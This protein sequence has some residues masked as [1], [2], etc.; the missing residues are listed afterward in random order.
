MSV[1]LVAKRCSPFTPNIVL[2]LFSL[3]CLFVKIS[4]Q[5]NCWVGPDLCCSYHGL[6][7]YKNLCC[8]FSRFV[9]LVR[10]TW[11]KCWGEGG[12]GG[13]CTHAELSLSAIEL[14]GV[15]FPYRYLVQ[16]KGGLICLDL[17]LLSPCFRSWPFH[18]VQEARV[19]CYL[20]WTRKLR[21]CKV[22]VN[23]KLLFCF[24][25]IIA[26]CIPGT[27]VPTRRKTQVM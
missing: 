19:I 20:N 23:S 22:A 3:G 8:T 21:L 7:S 18:F 9:L 13:C 2:L 16:M 26:T 17:G 14:F 4:S 27:T 5:S 12:P 15:F 10:T 24:N 11:Y 6:S 25:C 1:A